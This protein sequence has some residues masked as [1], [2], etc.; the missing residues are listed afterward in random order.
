MLPLRKR[1]FPLFLFCA[2]LAAWGLTAL[3][4]LLADD[5]IYAFSYADGS[6]LHSLD[7]VLYSLRFHTDYVNGR[8]LSHFFVMSFM[9]LPK[10][11]FN[12]CN[13]LV[14]TAGL[15]A[16]AGFLRVWGR[17]R[18]LPLA[19]ALLWL[20]MPVFGQVCLWLDGS[21]N[22]AWGLALALWVLLPFYKAYCLGAWDWPLWKRLVYLPLC[23]AAGAWS[24]HISLSLL[25]AAFLLLL[26]RALE[27]KRLRLYPLLALLC[28]ALG[29]LTLLLSPKMLRTL[30]KL[31]ADGALGA[32]LTRYLPL[33]LGALALG[34][35]AL[36]LLRR[37]GKRGR[38]GGLC[39][40]LRLLA[41]LCWLAAAGYTALQALRDS[42]TL[43]AAL[44]ALLSS[45]LLGLLSALALAAFALLTALQNGTERKRLLAAALLFVSGLSCFALYPLAAYF[46]ARASAS[47]VQF[48]V[49]AALTL[50]EAPRKKAARRALALCLS[51]LL[52]ISL[53]LGLAD[54][55]DLHQQRVEREA[56]IREELATETDTVALRS[57]GCKTKYAA[58][59]GLPDLDP[60]GS[61]WPRDPI[62]MY[63]GIA[64]VISLPYE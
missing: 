47:A 21:C 2:F 55:V 56:H 23:F 20:C 50:L 19:A 53:A 62:G 30:R 28:G 43:L 9:S 24:E 46:P 45:S 40:A 42:A 22:Y 51:V 26:A 41:V 33:L 44:E 18:R 14:L 61:E 13:A 59:Y 49:L 25:A 27:E 17:E 32:K 64:H 37:L 10:G 6:R 54:I 5:F 15:A 57:F 39:R 7:G 31:F 58:L 1:A 8:V 48:S 34:L 52:L 63:Y 16:Q 11:V 35:A 60:P 3:T 12:L 4:P 36:W 29:Y 38:L